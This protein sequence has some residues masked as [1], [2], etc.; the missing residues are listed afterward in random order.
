MSCPEG[1]LF[2]RKLK[3][4]LKEQETVC[5]NSNSENEICRYSLDGLHSDP[6]SFDCKNYVKCYNKKLVSKHRCPLAT[7][8]NGTSCIPDTLYECPR[9][10]KFDKLCRGKNDGFHVDPRY[11]CSNYMKCIRNY[12]V[13]FYHCNKGLVFDPETKNC[14][15]KNTKSLCRY[16]GTSNDCMNSE[17]GYYQDRSLDS[18]CREYYFCYNGKK[19]TFR[20]ELGKVF[21][22]ENCVDERLYTC[23]NLDENSCDNKADGYYKDKSG[24]RAYFYCSGGRKYSYVCGDG[25]AFDGNKCVEKR[26]VSQCAPSVECTG[27][28]DGYYQDLTSDCRNYYFCMQGDKIQLLTCRN[29]RLFN[30]QSC[31]SPD[32]YTCPRGKL[33]AAKPNCLPRKCKVCSKNGFFADLDSACRNYYF[34]IDGR[35]TFLSCS[36][37]YVFNGEICVPKNSYQCPQYCTDQ[38]SD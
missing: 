3:I 27:K 38:C 18:S 20:C 11:G 9:S 14:V 30:G 1:F 33:K 28:S 13:E 34:C 15:S 2:D 31:V 19:T 36:D 4:C 23:P 21:N 17:P 10:V 6:F 25:Q 26:H 8:F 29:G 24:C 12:P 35:P 16:L 7:I 32:S 22:G 5:Q 37:N